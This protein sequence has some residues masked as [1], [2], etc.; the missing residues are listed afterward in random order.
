[1]IS[2]VVYETLGCPEDCKKI[3]EIFVDEKITID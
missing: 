2:V 3:D 1:M